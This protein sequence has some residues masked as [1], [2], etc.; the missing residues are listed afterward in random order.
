MSTKQL[1]LSLQEYNEDMQTKYNQ[2]ILHGTNKLMAIVED[3]I[4]NDG[5]NI[6]ISEN[7]DETLV[8]FIE[9]IKSLKAN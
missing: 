2:G 4:E 3:I 1:T 8:A 5:A 9:K 7:A 6:K